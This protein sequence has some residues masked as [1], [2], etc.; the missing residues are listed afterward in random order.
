[1]KF[2]LASES[3]LVQLAIFTPPS[4]GQTRKIPTGGQ[5]ISMYETTETEKC[6]ALSQFGVNY[7]VCATILVLDAALHFFRKCTD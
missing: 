3:R 6:A 2:R 7:F 4:S 5:L 1:M